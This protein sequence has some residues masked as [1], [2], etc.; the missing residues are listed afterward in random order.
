[1]VSLSKNER[2]GDFSILNNQEAL[3]FLGVV[4]RVVWFIEGLKRN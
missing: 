4:L 3:V 1:M 2:T